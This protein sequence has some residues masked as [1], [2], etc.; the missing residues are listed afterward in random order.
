MYLE[1]SGLKSYLD[2]LEKDLEKEK[3]DKETLLVELIKNPKLKD[4][5]EKSDMEHILS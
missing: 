1:N 2:Q 4:F 5:Q 3:K